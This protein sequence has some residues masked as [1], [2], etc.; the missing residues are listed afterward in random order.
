MA[1]IASVLLATYVVT[2]GNGDHTVVF[3][4]QKYTAADELTM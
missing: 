4:F 3:Q 1:R 2:M